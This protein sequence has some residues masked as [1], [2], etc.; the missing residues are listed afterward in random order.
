MKILILG[1]G[2]MGSF[3]VD[4]L[5]F[6]HETAVYDVDPK[7]LRFMYNT[8][9]FTSLEEIRDFAPEL[10]I[11]AVTLKHTLDVFRQVIPYL[12]QECILS[13][14][15]SVKTGIQAF[16]ESCGHRYVSTHPM[17]GPTFANLGALAS[18]NAIVISEGD[19]MGRIFF[20]D[21]YSKLGLNICEYT[22]DEHDETVAYSLSI[23]FVSTFVFAAVMKHQ[24][25][26]G[27]TFKRHMAIAKGVLGEDDCLL[28]E[29]LFNP[30]TGG[31][32]SK[33][34]DELKEM[35]EIIDRKDEEALNN[36]LKKIREHIK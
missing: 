18:E 12:P 13:D 30:R 33:I 7:R 6:E 16:Y 8:Q 11:N 1:A 27:T 24:D 14:I 4:L 3:F 35:L 22:F 5:S 21:L 26:P 10:V 17:F 34:R 31:Q 19:Y 32:V 36:Y 28:R 20:K 15:A 29:I 2:K 23:P 9:R 25:A